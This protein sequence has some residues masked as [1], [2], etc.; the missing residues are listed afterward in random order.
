MT[1][2]ALSIVL[3]SAAVAVALIATVFT[4]RAFL[5][6]SGMDLRGSFSISSSIAC[7]DKYVSHVTIENAKDRAAVL[8]GIYV[9]LGHGHYIEVENFEN[10]P[11]IIPPFGIIRRNYDP[12]EFYSSN[13][14]RVRIE[15]LLEGK[16][17]RQRL[18]LS[19]AEGRYVVRKWIKHWMPVFDF[20]KNH[21]TFILHQKRS[22][23]Q[24]KAYG[25]NAK[26]ILVITLTDGREEVIPVFEDDHRFKKFKDFRLSPESLQSKEALEEFLLERAVEGDLTCQDLSV[27]DLDDW[28]K[29]V[30]EDYRSVPVE[31]EPQGWWLYHLVGPVFTWWRN[32]DLRRKNRKNRKR[33]LAEANNPGLLKEG[34]NSS[35]E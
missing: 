4:A 9:E 5:L 22:I 15:R 12:I 6:K 14:K 20:F 28:R 1:P 17:A 2:E 7:E 13:M 33:R 21:L 31:L 11:L 19:T 27:L 34:E 29:E 16:R 10:E 23:Y 3:S 32:W 24:G 25:S 30:Y 35:P 26:F 18:V 8:F